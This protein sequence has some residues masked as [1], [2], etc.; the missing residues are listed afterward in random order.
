MRMHHG[1]IILQRHVANQRQN[2]QLF[3][4]F[5]GALLA[6]HAWTLSRGAAHTGHPV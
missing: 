4:E 1:L 3:V 5:R 6:H 2:L